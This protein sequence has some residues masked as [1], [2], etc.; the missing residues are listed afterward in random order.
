MIPLSEPHSTSLPTAP[1]AAAAPWAAVLCFAA[2]VAALIAGTTLRAQTVRWDPPGGQLGHNQVSELSLSFENCEPE[3]APQLPKVDGLTFGSNPSQRTEVSMVNFDVTRRYMLTYPVRPTKRSAISIPAFSVNTDKGMIRVAAA[4]FTVGDASVGN[5]GLAVEDISSAILDVPKNTF[6]AGEVFPVTYNLSV[7][8]RYFHSPGTL[9]EWQA[10]P[11]ILEEW[12]KPQPSE[13]MVRGERRFVVTQSTRAYAKTPGRLSLKPAQ[14]LVNLVVGSTGFGLFATPAVEQRILTSEPLELT[15]K[16]LPA[17]PADFSGAVGQFS[18]VSKVVP[19]SP[20]VG[21][22]ITWTLELTGTGNWPDLAGLP[23]REVSKDFSVVQPKSKR[24]M[25]DN[26]LFE[27]TLTEDVVLVPTQPGRY[28]LPSVKFTYFDPASGTYKTITTEAVTVNVGAAAPAPV[29]GQPSGPVQFAL[30]AS[31]TATAAPGPQIPDA[32]APVPPENLPRDPLATSERGYA[33]IAAPPL[34]TV[35]ALAPLLPPLIFWLFLAAQRSRALD[36]QRRRREAHAALTQ[37]L[38]G[39]RTACA[40]PAALTAQLREWQQHAAALWEIPHAAPGE[41]LVRAAVVRL[42]GGAKTASR[43]GDRGE[44]APA[45]VSSPTAETWS[46]LWAEADRAQHSREGAL[47]SDWPVRAAAALRDVKVPGWPVFSLFAPRHLLPFLFTL[48]VLAAPLG[49]QAAPTDDYKRGDFAAAQ[50][51]WRKAVAAAP[52]DWAARHNLGLAY[53]QQDRWAEATAHWTSGF[54]LAPRSDLTRAD[55]AL[56]L[57]RSG[58]APSE[59]VELSRGEGRHA[60]ARA[61]SPGEWQGVLV[62]AALGLAAALLLL[63]L[64]GYGK[65]GAWARPTALAV[66]LLAILAAGTATLALRIYGQLAD[67]TAVFVWRASTLRSIPTEA[68]TQK[69]TALSAGSLATVDKTF[70]GWSRLTFA[71]GQTGW[72]RTDDLIALYR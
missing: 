9:V 24:T 48:L 54:L 61:A 3:G 69:V 10:A 50:A 36:P 55:L 7:I 60:L 31:N 22:P 23:Q 68:D 45:P 46:T 41:P 67:P 34:L 66:V 29:A 52:T 30:P 49:A 2:L 26:S 71:G 58:L 32:V 6:W 13:T 12:S 21:E 16:P 4:N 14:Q 35:V 40:S 20:A 17:A 15:I 18:L 37:L 70:L 8:K 44:S 5:S 47:P 38:A 51:G 62:L 72:A 63:L 25:K 33:P 1:R 57:Q 65:I 27:G 64:K 11:L 53:A 19:T 42:S 43:A 28:T 56:G 59:L 39:L